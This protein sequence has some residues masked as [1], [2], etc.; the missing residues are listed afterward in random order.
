MLQKCNSWTGSVFRQFIFVDLC[1]HETL[2]VETAGFNPS[3]GMKVR[4]LYYTIYL[5]GKGET[6]GWFEQWSKETTVS[7]T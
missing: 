1:I 4:L 7:P 5:D 2:A 6:M 3:L